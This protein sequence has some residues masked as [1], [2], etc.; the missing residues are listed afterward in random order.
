MNVIHPSPSARA[1][2]A[3]RRRSA[4][5]TALVGVAVALA[6]V[7]GTAL[8]AAAHDELVD[9]TP[10]LTDDGSP[11][12][13]ETGP[14]E[15]VLTYSADVLQGTAV[16]AVIDENGDDHVAGPATI[17][18]N[19]VTAPVADDL[20]AGSYEARWAVT[21]SDGHP[22]SGIIPFS[23][24]NGAAVSPEPSASAAPSDQATPSA[25]AAPKDT[26]TPKD[27]APPA[28]GSDAGE[29][30]P[31][32][33]IVIGVVVVGAII[34]ILVTVLMRRRSAPGK[35]SSSDTDA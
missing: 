8:P 28:S 13:L 25:T 17:V 23:V 19:I 5:R 16:V 10:A 4:V 32:L 14:A 27:T 2:R 20:A 1:V 9:S 18:G 21:S 22:I 24:A 3:A 26:A 33:G 35:G 30:G 29:A 34:V 12:V 31:L 6:A 7:L 15:I 11:A